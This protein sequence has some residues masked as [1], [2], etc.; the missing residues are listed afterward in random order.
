[1]AAG[2]LYQKYG[3]QNVGRRPRYYSDNG[4]D[5]LIMTTPPLKSSAYQAQYGPLIAQRLAALHSLNLPP[6]TVIDCLSTRIATP[7]VTSA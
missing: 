4:E 1:L 3:F 6:Q 2:R 5:A 7:T